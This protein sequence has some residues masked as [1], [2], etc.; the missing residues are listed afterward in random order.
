MPI[1]RWNFMRNISP[2]SVAS[3]SH[4]R[5]IPFKLISNRTGGPYSDPNVIRKLVYLYL[6]KDGGRQKQDLIPIQKRN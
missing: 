4:E 5:S 3:I 2:E 1:S 6:L